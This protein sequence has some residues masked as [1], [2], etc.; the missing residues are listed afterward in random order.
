VHR[1]RED[2]LSYMIGALSITAFRLLLIKF[3]LF[4]ILVHDRWTLFGFSILA[5][6]LL[7][8]AF[9]DRRFYNSTK[10]DVLGIVSLLSTTVVV[11]LQFFLAPLKKKLWLWIRIF[12]TASTV[13][14]LFYFLKVDGYADA[15]VF[16][17]IS[18]ILLGLL[19]IYCWGAANP[20]E[21]VNL[22]PAAQADA[23]ANQGVTSRKF[24]RGIFFCF[25]ILA[26]VLSVLTAT[27][28]C[29]FIEYGVS[30]H[31]KDIQGRG[32]LLVGSFNSDASEWQCHRPDRDED[33]VD[34][35]AF[36]NVTERAVRLFVEE[37]SEGL[38]TS[39]VMNATKQITARVIAKKSLHEGNT[40]VYSIITFTSAGLAMDGVIILV[41]YIQRG[42]RV[43]W[44]LVRLCFVLAAV[45]QCLTLTTSFD[46]WVC[47]IYSCT[48]GIAGLVATVNVAILALLAILSFIVSPPTKPAY[49]VIMSR[50]KK[51]KEPRE[52]SPEDQAPTADAKAD[53]ASTHDEAKQDAKSEGSEDIGIPPVPQ[54]VTSQ[55]SDSSSPHGL[56]LFGSS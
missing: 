20:T 11:I 29:T 26:F 34:K 33:R 22:D 25:S 6:V 24:I 13:T 19:S 8:L 46:T 36:K 48:L 41:L 12:M 52:A 18:L 9:I 30:D 38:D 47:Q 1:A 17:L 27:T 31:W 50:E 56:G 35:V 45:F 44:W 37:H 3:R 5:W 2:C 10:S 28:Q 43:I 32:P 49:E 21:S 7:T 53:D 39:Q 42:K 14:T 4:V 54:D 55:C 40:W 15:R 23:Q 51:I 16:S